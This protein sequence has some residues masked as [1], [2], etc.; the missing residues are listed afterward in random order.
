MCFCQVCDLHGQAVASACGGL[1]APHV[2]HMC[3][4]AVCTRLDSASLPFLPSNHQVLPAHPIIKVAAS[5]CSGSAN[6]GPQGLQV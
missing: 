5:P 3:L 2:P 1:P 6:L 4:P